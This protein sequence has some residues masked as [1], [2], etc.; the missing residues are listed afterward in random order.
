MSS[1]PNTYDP[2]AYD[3]DADPIQPTLSQKVRAGLGAGLSGLSGILG[4]G[5]NTMAAAGGSPAQSAQAQKNLNPQQTSLA[6][7][8]PAQID[9]WTGLP[10]QQPNFALT[11]SAVGWGLR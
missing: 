8:Q 1:T 9:P 6:P 2:N 3:P 7:Q 5:G 11:P 4:S 10:Q